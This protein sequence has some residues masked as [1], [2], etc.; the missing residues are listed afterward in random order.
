MIDV[1]GYVV[2]GA[3]AGAGVLN[4]LKARLH[5]VFK[6]S[7]GAVIVLLLALFTEHAFSAEQLYT[8]LQ[9]NGF[10]NLACFL[11]IFCAL[12]YK[13]VQV[14]LPETPDSLKPRAERFADYML[15]F[16]TFSLIAALV[17]LHLNL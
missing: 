13:A 3:L 8:T 6:M 14:L 16:S 5:W 15:G 9:A 7:I 11:A 4:S 10:I 17:V 2:V 12:V 1:V